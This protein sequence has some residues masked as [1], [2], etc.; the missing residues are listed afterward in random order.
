MANN[1]KQYTLQLD[2]QFE[3]STHLDIFRKIAINLKKN[4]QQQQF[5]SFLPKIFKPYI[6]SNLKFHSICKE[7]N[8]NQIKQNKT[9]TK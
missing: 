4:N 8:K 5:I 2:N 6:S 1:R 7:I 9:K 3:L